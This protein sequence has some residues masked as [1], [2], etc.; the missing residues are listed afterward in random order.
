LVAQ[1]GQ[2]H[3]QA[4]SRF[5]GGGREALEEAGEWLGELGL[6]GV[7]EDQLG[8]EGEELE[9]ADQ[10]LLV[11]PQAEGAG[12]LLGLE[13]RVDA[14]QEGLLGDVFVAVLAGAG[15]LDL[16]VELLEAV[17]DDVEVGE[18]HFLTEAGELLG[19]VGAGE[20]VEDDEEPAGLAEDAE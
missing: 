14:L 12:V 3:L 6:A 2:L 15:L 20:A 18:E 9:A 8:L 11:G 13:G 10:L 16:V 5:Q 1:V 19:E 4:D 17:A 7:D